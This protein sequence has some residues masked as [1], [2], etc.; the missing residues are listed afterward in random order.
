MPVHTA[1][2]PI[3]T[4]TKIFNSVSRY[5]SGRACNRFSELTASLSCGSSTSW[6]AQ[7]NHIFARL[8]DQA[9]AQLEEYGK[10]ATSPI[11]WLPQSLYLP[12][13]SNIPEPKGHLLLCP[14]GDFRTAGN[15]MRWPSCPAYW[16]LD[17]SGANPLTPEDAKA[18]GFPLIHLE[19]IMKGYSWD[20]SLY[21]GVRQF[22]L[23]KGFNPDTQDV[24]RRLNY[25]LFE[26]L[27]REGAPAAYDEIINWDPENGAWC[28]L[29]DHAYCQAL[30]HY[31]H[32]LPVKWL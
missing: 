30:G 17:P 13:P 32:R 16:S 14:P 27:R 6:M 19:T 10:V 2:V 8:H 4:P 20:N 28:K 11:W 23:G 15:S 1:V 26:L 9:S 7:A 12:N 5:G 25:P 18:L 31:R 29:Q 22:H 24:A 21:A 3:Q